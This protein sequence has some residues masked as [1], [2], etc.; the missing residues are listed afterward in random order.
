MS[1]RNI[2]VIRLLA[3]KE[4]DEGREPAV[5][6]GITA[7]TGQTRSWSS[8]SRIRMRITSDPWAP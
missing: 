5:L 7:T 1:E 8:I 3:G 6:S 2:A 4:K